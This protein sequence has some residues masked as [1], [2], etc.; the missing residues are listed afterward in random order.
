MAWS[1]PTRQ[2]K[3]TLGTSFVTEVG[4]NGKSVDVGLTSPRTLDDVIMGD[5]M[6]KLGSIKGSVATGG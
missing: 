4:G 2:T 5:G 1:N 3:Y 6:S